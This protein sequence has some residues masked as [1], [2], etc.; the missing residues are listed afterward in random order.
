MNAVSTRADHATLVPKR[1]LHD[2]LYDFGIWPYLLLLVFFSDVAPEVPFLR[3]C[4]L[5]LV[6]TCACTWFGVPGAF[7]WQTRQRK[8]EHQELGPLRRRFVV[9]AGMLDV[10]NSWAVRT[11]VNLAQCYVAVLLQRAGADGCFD[12]SPLEVRD[13]ENFWLLASAFVFS[14]VVVGVQVIVNI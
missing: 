14:S 12:R 2:Y 3:V 5:K 13:A 7:S 10:V 1:L 4:A 6:F 9:L 8:R 11:W